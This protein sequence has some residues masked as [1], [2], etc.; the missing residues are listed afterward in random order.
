MKLVASRLSRLG[1]LLLALLPMLPT[2]L[3]VADGAEPLV[4]VADETAEEKE[5]RKKFRERGVEPVSLERG[6]PVYPE[7]L[8]AAGVRGEVRVDFIV[9]TA[10][11][12]KNPKV[13]V[14]NNPGFDRAAIE[15]IRQWKF[16]PGL[17]DG[18]AVE[19]RASQW[20]YFHTD[21]R[22]ES[23]GFW[24]PLS[25]KGQKDLPEEYHWDKAPEPLEMF[26]PVYPRAAL[27]AGTKGKVRV[28]F[29]IGPRGTV[30]SAKVVESSAREMELAVLAMLDTWRF[31]PPLKKDGTPCFAAVS[32]EQKFLPNGKGD[33]TVGAKAL[34]I[35]EWLKKN[36]E[37][38]L[39]LKQLDQP[40][41]PVRRKAPVY[42]SALLAAGRKGEAEIEFFIDEKGRAQLPAILSATE[43]EFGY[44][45]A[46]AIAGWRFEP[47]LRDGKP[48]VVRVRIPLDF[49][50]PK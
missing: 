6:T 16:K 27:A 36:P 15:A 33:P 41:K 20:I 8:E 11:R 13:A 2:V 48:A 30:V 29:V 5:F 31:T 32:T 43:P 7:E 25:R 1:R 42:P 22:N 34:Q 26:F 9:D 35:L 47:P 19:V 38:I 3:P 39:S 24:N 44:A 45:A 12:V 50:L 14:S 37:K 28:N 17:L 46:Q 23:T 49:T 18:R 40:I 4:A 10:G 21:L